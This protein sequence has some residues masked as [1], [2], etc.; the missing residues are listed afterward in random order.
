V[1]VFAGL[2]PETADV[3]VPRCRRA[4]NEY[5]PVAVARNVTV[6]VLMSFQRENAPLP[7][8]FSTTY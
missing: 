1:I 7:V 3:L 6:G 4:R 5:E 2:G 8:F